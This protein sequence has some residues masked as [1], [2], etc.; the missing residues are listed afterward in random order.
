M[1]ISFDE[2]E[3]RRLGEEVRS[4]RENLEATSD[5]LLD[6]RKRVQQ[7]TQELD[8]ELEKK[9]T[10]AA[11]IERITDATISQLESL[12]S[13]NGS[14]TQF[15]SAILLTTKFLG[16]AAEKIPV[17]TGIVSG[18]IKSLGPI[19][20]SIL[21]NYEKLYKEFSTL[22]EAGLVRSVDETRES[23]YKSGLTLEDLGK[24]YAKYSKELAHFGGTAIQ[25]RIEFEK[26]ANESI[27]VRDTFRRLGFTAAEFNDYQLG[28][29]HNLQ[30]TGQLEGKS[31]TQ[32]I[33]M[34]EDYLVNL[35]AVS[36]LTGKNRKEIQKELEDRQRNARYRALTRGM[37]DVEK[38]KFDAFLSALGEH[39]EGAIDVMAGAFGTQAARAMTVNYQDLAIEMRDTFQQGIMPGTEM[40]NK[41]IDRAKIVVETNEE[42]V[43]I[44]GTEILLTSKALADYDIASRK[45][46]KNF[47]EVL[48]AQREQL[49][50]SKDLNATIAKQLEGAYKT[51]VNLE[52]AAVNLDALPNLTQK[53]TGAVESITGSLSKFGIGLNN[54][55]NSKG[56][57][58]ETTPGSGGK[59]PFGL[60]ASAAG[61][62]GA[63]APATSTGFI[64]ASQ[65]DLASRFGLKM[66]QGDVQREN[67]TINSNLIS[68]AKRAQDGIPGFSYFSAFNDNHRRKS[69]KHSQGVAMD[70]VL[71]YAPTV[72]QGR[73]IVS[74][75]K[76][77]GASYA[78]DEYNNDSPDR[79]G[80]H[81]HAEISALRGGIASGPYSGFPATLHGNELI[82]PLD[83]NSILEKLAT[84]P[85]SSLVNSQVDSGFTRLKESIDK[86]RYMP[87]ELNEKFED[88]IKIM[89]DIRN[90]QNTIMKRTYA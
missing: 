76:S 25:G 37:D 64:N 62:A 9:K 38:K 53:L 74:K 79:T 69:P 31:N 83:K 2:D 61:A 22:T 45:H 50:N 24:T 30:L 10:R 89:S 51:Q 4:T 71:N 8:K 49:K 67:G 1:A 66:K 19:T 40:L 90:I 72:E 84:T 41:F 34:T 42:L 46:F 60:G 23:F 47:D 26:L 20:A 12:S 82:K 11:K 75:L 36:V 57:G 5:P 55:L 14:L 73:E 28:Y 6:F 63:A 65:T 16:A 43:K 21:K 78:K 77:M 59:L 32:L 88:L 86:I 81:M 80:P 85:A 48:E 35:T 56:Y 70:F 58:V 15:N 17:F 33:K 13:G 18:V 39:Q 52:T 7:T 68:L 3:W 29:L 27:P 87:H 44:K 54:F